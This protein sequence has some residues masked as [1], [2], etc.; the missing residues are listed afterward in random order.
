M[1]AII[2]FITFN[3]LKYTKIL[4]DSIR[5]SYPHEI[6]VFD[7]GSIDGTQAWLKEK[8]NV[9]L[10]ENGQNLGVPYCSNS[11]YDYT[12]CNDKSNLLIVLSNDMVCLPNAIDDLIRATEV[13][14][15]SVISG[16]AIPSPIY[17][18]TYPE[19]R[20]FFLGGNNI[21]T[22]VSNMAR[23]SHGKLY[24]ILEDKKDEFISTMYSRLT[25][26]LPE[27]SVRPIEG[28]GW[29][30]PGHRV[31]RYEYFEK[32]GYWDANFYPLYA[33]DFDMA[34]RAKLTNQK[35]YIVYSSLIYEFWSRGLYEG[36]VPFKDKRRDDYLKDKWG[37]HLVGTNGW[38]VP[39]NGTFPDK[40]KGYDTSQVRISTREGELERIKYLMGS[41]FV[42]CSDPKVS[43]VNGENFYREPAKK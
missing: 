36:I 34:M 22:N 25:P 30:V 6:L 19:D 16:D 20:K 15:A 4:Y 10:V 17:L 12:W 42:S 41:S 3:N 1:K 40:Y 11:M 39:F 26:K 14:D 32:T 5:C 43:G 31:Y 23:W 8:P 29:Y 13:C 28:E 35:C 21:T 24:S 38:D 27:F 37:P 33:M 7:N 9:T 2:S 18:A